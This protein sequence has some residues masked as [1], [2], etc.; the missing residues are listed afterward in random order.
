MT[1]VGQYKIKKRMFWCFWSDISATP[2]YGYS[3]DYHTESEAIR[4]ITE[5][6]AKEDRVYKYNKG[7]K[8]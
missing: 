6:E 4:K 5:L 2:M 1:D 3:P 7:S 8:L